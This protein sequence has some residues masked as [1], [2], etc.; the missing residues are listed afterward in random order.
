MNIYVGNL[1]FAATEEDVRQA[2][3]AFGQVASVALIKD[4]MTGKPRGFGFVEMPVEAEANAAIQGLNGKN[5]MN[6]ALV[7][8]PARPREEGGGGGG[9]FGARRR[10]MGGDRGEG[11][12]RRGGPRGG[13]DRRR[14]DY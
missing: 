10:P 1:P 5:M 9:G 7:V 11:G 14:N 13:G 3:A 8:N 2:F 12:D 6:R 4:K